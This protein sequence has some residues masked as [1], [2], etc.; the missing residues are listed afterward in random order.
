MIAAA[1]N[2]HIMAWKATKKRFITFYLFVSRFRTDA[3][4]MTYLPLRPVVWIGRA[5][6]GHGIKLKCAMSFQQVLSMLF[7]KVRCFIFI[8]IGTVSGGMLQIL[9]LHRLVRDGLFVVLHN[10]SVVAM[11]KL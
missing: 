7:G 11:I 10:Y 5:H 6:R 4:L 1:G 8:Q 2:A 9:T 3:C